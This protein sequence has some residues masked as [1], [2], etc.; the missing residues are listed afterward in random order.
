MAPV[1]GIEQMVAEGRAD[2]QLALVG[3]H[4]PSVRRLWLETSTSRRREVL[5]EIPADFW[6]GCG[7]PGIA[8]VTALGAYLGKQFGH[9]AGAKAM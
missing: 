2:R 5:G 8:T 3:E 9:G 7:M 6:I 1:A 4:W